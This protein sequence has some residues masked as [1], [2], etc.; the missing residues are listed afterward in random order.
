MTRAREQLDRL[1]VFDSYLSIAFGLMS[2]IAPHGALQRLG[3]GFYN[4]DV[5]ELLR[6]VN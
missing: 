2:L 4:H 6:C 1:L 5:H 3:G